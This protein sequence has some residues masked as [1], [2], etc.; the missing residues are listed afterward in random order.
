MIAMIAAIAEVFFFSSD[1][2]DGGDHMETGL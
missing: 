2:S 1:H